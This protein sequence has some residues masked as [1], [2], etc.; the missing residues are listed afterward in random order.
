MNAS[1][2]GAGKRSELVR[3]NGLSHSLDDSNARIKMLT[4]IG[5]FLQAAIGK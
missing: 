2:T 1:L 3:F 4:R 5:E